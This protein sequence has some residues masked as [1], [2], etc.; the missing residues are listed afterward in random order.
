[1]AFGFPS[2]FS[3]GLP[4]NNFTKNQ[5]IITAIEISKKLNWQLIEIIDNEL[6]FE[7]INSLNTWNENIYISVEKEAAYL[8]SSSNG[9]QIYDKGRNKKNIDAFLESFYD[10][11]REKPSEDDNGSFIH[12][13]ISNEKIKA[14][15]YV[16]E[17]KR[18]TVF[19]SFFSLF[20]PTKDY[21]ITPIIIYI[22]VLI[23]LI[24]CFSGVN[25]FSPEINDIIDWG[26]NYGPLTI[27]NN[28][29]RLVSS[30]FVHIGIVHLLMNCIA[31][32]YVGLLLEPNLK[33][34][35]F[36]ITYFAAGIIASLSSLYWNNNLVSAGASGAIF[37]MYGILLVFILFGIIDKKI[38]A[39]LLT[40]III[41]IVINVLGSF[42]EGVDGAAHIGGLSFGLVAGAILVVLTKNRKIALITIS[43]FT[44]IVGACLITTCRDT[45]VFIYELDKYDAGMKDF[46]E[47]EKL[48]LESYNEFG[49]SGATKEHALYMIQ[50]RGIYYWEENIVLLQSLERLSL[51]ELLHDQNKNL[52]KYCELR[53][54]SFKLSY[55]KLNENSTDYD[56][57]IDDLN[58]EINDLIV[59][60][61]NNF[62]KQSNKIN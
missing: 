21:F 50:E 48:A 60:V 22:N 12:E 7:T 40:T 15:S 51:P 35:G 53:I 49:Y 31:L 18:I 57:D 43:S 38:N 61:K 41:F 14:Q 62:E 47:M 2:S 29:W 56:N 25:P 5:F 16:S 24:M 37:G 20:I 36:L 32:A 44:I 55:K 52:I 10:E 46:L 11:K 26:G 30:C 54:K 59:V 23:F 28:W 19:Y 17:E 9:S 42:E 27:E 8:T 4:L 33:R 39:N 45:K 3:H 6:I 13:Y 34:W 1:M 58:S